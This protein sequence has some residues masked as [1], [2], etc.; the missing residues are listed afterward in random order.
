[1]IGRFRVGGPF[2][3]ANRGEGT[4]ST[5]CNYINN[6]VYKYRPLV[7]VIV[8]LEDK[9]NSILLKNWTPGFLPSIWLPA[10]PEL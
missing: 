6:A 4:T 7:I 10:P 5:T 1:M 3:V 9:I 2:G 8:A